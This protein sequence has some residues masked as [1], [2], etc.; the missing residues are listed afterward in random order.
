MARQLSGEESFK[1]IQEGAYIDARADQFFCSF[2]ADGTA[3]TSCKCV[4]LTQAWA[5]TA[6]QQISKADQSA[7]V[8]REPS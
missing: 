3:K 4:L 2:S 1:G 6:R 7:F 5:F 8:Q